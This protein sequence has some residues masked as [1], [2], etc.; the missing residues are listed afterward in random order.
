M[1]VT[2]DIFDNIGNLPT[3]SLHETLVMN[4]PYKFAST[5]GM[6][7]VGDKFAVTPSNKRIVIRV[8]I[9]E[10]KTRMLDIFPRGWKTIARPYHNIEVGKGAI[11]QV[12]NKAAIDRSLGCKVGL[13]NALLIITPIDRL[14]TFELESHVLSDRDEGFAPVG[15]WQDANYNGWV[16]APFDFAPKHYVYRSSLRSVN[17]RDGST[18]K[19]LFETRS[20]VL[21]A[22][23]FAALWN[24]KVCIFSKERQSK[25]KFKFAFDR[26]NLLQLNEEDVK[27]LL[28]EQETC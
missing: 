12:L 22:G 7:R 18:Y 5:R 13:E 6:L 2:L 16:L 1:V 19:Y 20:N 11:V 26:D 27:I 14:E 4:I 25:L 9:S 21:K 8:P 24:D 3:E 15:S 28:G 23:V 17:E 10:L